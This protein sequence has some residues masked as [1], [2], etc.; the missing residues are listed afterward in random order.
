MRLRV[1]LLASAFALAA[2]GSPE[3]ATA[4]ADR[5]GGIDITANQDRIRAQ[6]VDAIAALVPAE[7]RARGT[8]VVGTTG[9]G[10]PPL[11]FRADDDKTVIGV[12]PDLAQLVADVLGLK[13]DLR[14]S[15]WEN[16]F[17]SVENRQFDAGFSNITVTEERKDKYDFATYRKDTI[18]FEVRKEKALAVQGPKDI[19]G[20]TVGVG[21][22]T[23]QEQILLRWDQQNKAAG[24]APVKFQYYQATSD[25]YLALRSGR[26]DAYVGPNPTAAYHVAV[27]GTTKIAGTVS[28]GGTIPADIAAM[29][30]KDDG[31]VQALRQALDA[32]IK[33]GRYA[34]VL[35]RWN[36]TSEALPA[37][38]VN[39]RGLPRK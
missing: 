33:D 26:I 38:E 35:K 3:A 21:A 7:I 18:A 19:A 13:L 2:C 8:L 27:D 9:N 23:N 22:G 15:S 32:L 28:G 6:K 31:L 4:P 36:L 10:T 14:A 29:T 20:L 30:K 24:L 39:P 17:L 5:P 25:Y 12:E 1:L 37:S 34:E 16:L 11:S